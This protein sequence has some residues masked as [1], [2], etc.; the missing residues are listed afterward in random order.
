LLIG[1]I[2]SLEGKTLTVALKGVN[3]QVNLDQKLCLYSG[4]N[5]IILR[6]SF[7]MVTVTKCE[8][9]SGSVKDIT[10]GAKVYIHREGKIEKK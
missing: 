10:I 6:A 9:V 5:M 1:Q 7:P 8:V 2:K 3:K 4:D